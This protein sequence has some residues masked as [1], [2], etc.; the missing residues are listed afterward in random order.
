MLNKIIEFWKSSDKYVFLPIIISLIFA[1][2]VTIFYF[3]YYS[4]LPERLPLFYSV[5][6]GENQLASKQQFLILPAT[7]MLILLINSLIASQLHSAQYILKRIIMLFLLIIS[8]IL[9]ITAFK[10]LF[11]FI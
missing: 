7:M 3:I 6:W 10:I 8:L 9:L 4:Q 1:L 5:S 2:S 11:I